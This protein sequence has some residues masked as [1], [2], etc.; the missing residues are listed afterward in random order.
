MAEI[1][2]GRVSTEEQNLDLQLQA[3]E[4]AGITD[5][6]VEKVK[7]D[8]DERPV[9][10]RLLRD[11]QPGDTLV[12]WA[13]DRL[14][15]SLIELL[16]IVT[17]LDQRGV[18]FKSLT[19]PI[20]TTTP[21]GWL[22]LQI[23]A[24]IAEFEKRLIRKRTKAGKAARAANGL[25]AGGPRTYG[26]AKDR[27]TVVPHE[28]AVLADAAARAL[29]GTPLAR[30][31]DELNDRGV[32]TKTPGA[33]WSE[34][35]LRRMLVHP[36]LVPAILS[37][38]QHDDLERLYANPTD[39]QHLGR[40]ATHLLSGILRC[41]CGAAMYAQ[42][43]KTR[44][45]SH[46][47]YTCRRSYGGRWQGCGK[48][49]IRSDTVEGWVTVAA[50]TAVCSERFADRLNARRAALLD[51]VNAEAL[52]D[53]R[54]EIGELEQVLGTRY[55]TDEH[56]GRLHQLQVEVR[57]ATARLVAAPDLTELLDLPRTRQGWEAA[58]EGWDTA[59]R[60]RKLRLLLT[61]VTV[62]A[63]GKG[64]RFNPDRL[65]PDWRF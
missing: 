1:G 55:G 28:A 40:P 5:P 13:L 30:V 37:K 60:R 50:A 43:V 17:D 10:D 32:P 54:V 34:T 26:L 39:R 64:V 4:R 63:T 27:Q 6:I 9:R 19:E 59:A 52:D 42:M 7:G 41:E 33:R 31:V 14:G 12:V 25:H 2:Y 23:M 57:K 16:T 24:A 47:A 48:V 58:W 56:R 8:A 53:M 22:V 46:E 35:T 15:R 29:D 45:V 36:G 38:A 51:G 62:R 21:F 18:K 20:D 49:S 3:F 65:D 61:K 44:G 11:L